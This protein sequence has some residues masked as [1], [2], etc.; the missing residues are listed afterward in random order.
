MKK[1]MFLRVASV[2]LVLTLL[3]TCAISGTFAKYVSTDTT[4][5]NA[6]VAY[7]GFGSDVMS[8]LDLFDG[9]Y[10]NVASADATNVVA[11]GTDKTATLTLTYTANGS[12]AAPEVAYTYSVT[13]EATT[14]NGYAAL[15]ANPNFKWT[16][17][18]PGDSTATEYNTVADLLAEITSTEEVAAGALPTGYT[19]GAATYEIGWTWLYNTYAD[20]DAPSTAELAQDATDTAMGN[21]TTPDDVTITISVAITQKD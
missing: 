18:A 17:K 5:D 13:A 1:N 10:T 20:P 9:T 11:P 12:T 16:L 6:R 21:D 2:L 4:S 3:S 7:W 8:E 19:A 15:D 14:T